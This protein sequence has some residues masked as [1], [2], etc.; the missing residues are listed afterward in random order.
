MR[1]RIEAGAI[2]AAQHGSRALDDDLEVVREVLYF[3]ANTPR[4]KPIILIT[5]INDELFGRDVT[6][7]LH[8]ES[9]VFVT[10]GH[11]PWGSRVAWG[12]A[13]CKSRRRVTLVL[14]Q[15]SWAFDFQ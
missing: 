13:W 11:E 4:G 5:W 9:G 15:A 10:T 8:A 7:R 2:A 12:P 3:L 14:M 6:T 1:R